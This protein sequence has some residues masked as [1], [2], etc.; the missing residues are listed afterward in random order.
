MNSLLCECGNARRAAGQGVLLPEM[1][2]GQVGF[3]VNSCCRTRRAEILERADTAAWRETGMQRRAE[4]GGNHIER[5]LDP[6][7]GVTLSARPVS[8]HSSINRIGPGECN[9]PGEPSRMMPNRK[10]AD[11]PQTLRRILGCKRAGPGSSI[12]PESGN[13]ASAPCA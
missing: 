11:T 9:F 12:L 6:I 8:A 3:S 10:A 7:V 4:A 1:V 13:Q 5:S 2:R